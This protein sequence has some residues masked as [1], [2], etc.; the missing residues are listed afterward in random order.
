MQTAPNTWV[1]PEDLGLA[2]K[3]ISEKASSQDPSSRGHVEEEDGKKHSPY[4]VFHGA[5]IG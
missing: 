1:C 3:Q 2:S 5:V 4:A